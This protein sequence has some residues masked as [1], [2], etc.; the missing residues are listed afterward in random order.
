MHVFAGGTQKNQNMV[1]PKTPC[2]LFLYA[3]GWHDVSIV[4]SNSL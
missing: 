1:V 3:V 2:T 4:Y